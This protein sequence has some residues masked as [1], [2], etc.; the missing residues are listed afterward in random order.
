MVDDVKFS[1]ELEARLDSELL[2]E[3]QYLMNPNV[4]ELKEQQRASRCMYLMG[5]RVAEYP[6]EYRYS[7]E[8][9]DKAVSELRRY[10]EEVAKSR[11]A[12]YFY[13]KRLLVHV[14]EKANKIIEDL[15]SQ[16]IEVG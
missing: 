2:K 16:G 14:Q 5:L 1:S 15:Q 11:M 8:P 4:E 10:G 3:F 7:K 9:S 13:W 12:E 6:E